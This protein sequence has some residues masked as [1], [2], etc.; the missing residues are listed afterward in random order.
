MAL[1]CHTALEILVDISSSN[2]LVPNRHHANTWTNLNLL[3]IGSLRTNLCKT[4]IK[5]H[6]FSLKKMYLKIFPEKSIIQF[7]QAW[8][9]SRVNDSSSQ[10]PSGERFK[11]TYELLNLRVL[12][13]S[14]VNKIHI[15]QCMGKTFC[16]KFQ[17]YPSKFHTKYL[18]H[19]LK[20]MIFI[21]LKSS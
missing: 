2:G 7:I 1:C 3:S 13:F 11:N 20:D 5:I 14:P 8:Q 18:T 4:L 19:T 15:F 6:I 17:R 9:V 10:T 12:K 21:H 16:V